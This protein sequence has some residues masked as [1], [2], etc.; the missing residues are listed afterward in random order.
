[1]TDVSNENRQDL[2][3]QVPERRVGGEFAAG[4]SLSEA[5]RVSFI[6]LKIIMIVLVLV[7]LASG[8]R[9]VGSDEKAL[10][11]QFGKINRVL[12]PGPHWVFPYPI[13]EIIKI[14]VGKKV[15]LAI[16]SFWYFQTPD[17]MLPAGPRTRPR[18]N[19]ALDPV[20]DGYCVTRN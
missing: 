11:L 17:E 3:S 16:G 9:T 7:F 18:I 14:P 20:R 5:L 2:Q 1:M 12:K 10:V 8:F 6:I 4:R 13:E 15:N 19:S